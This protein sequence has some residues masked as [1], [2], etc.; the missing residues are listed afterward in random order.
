MGEGPCGILQEDHAVQDSKKSEVQPSKGANTELVPVQLLAGAQV[1][2]EA[3]MTLMNMYDGLPT[4]GGQCGGLRS[5][6][7]LGL[8]LS[9]SIA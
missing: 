1:N 8:I 6:T 5:V 3:L 9:C 7:G 4:R 2:P